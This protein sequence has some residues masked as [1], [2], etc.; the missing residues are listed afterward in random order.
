MSFSREGSVLATGGQDC[1]V[2]LWNFTKLTEDLLSEEGASITP[3][4]KKLTCANLL[5]G[6]FPTKNIPT[7]GI[8]FTR[9][10]VLLASGPFQPHRENES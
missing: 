3:E 5:I 10:N 7:Y 2:R 1:C 8:H 4:A 6:E 9:R